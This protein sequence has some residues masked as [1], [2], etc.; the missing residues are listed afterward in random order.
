MFVVFR[1]GRAENVLFGDTHWALYGKATF[2]D[3][4]FFVKIKRCRK[5]LT[6]PGS[7]HVNA[8]AYSLLVRFSGLLFFKNPKKKVLYPKCQTQ[9]NISR[10]IC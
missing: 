1:Y 7:K 3:C 6:L 2:G 8:L 10:L 4:S 9:G 5:Y